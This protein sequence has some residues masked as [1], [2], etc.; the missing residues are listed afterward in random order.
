[1][2]LIPIASDQH[3]SA[4]CCEATGLG[5]VVRLDERTPNQ[6]KARTLAILEGTHFREWAKALS[7]DMA[8][9]PPLEYAVGLLEQLVSR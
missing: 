4:D 3:F 6:I 8:K 9:L 7:E 5:L 1:M 2:L